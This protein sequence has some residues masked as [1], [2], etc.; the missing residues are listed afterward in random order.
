M[1]Y[2]SHLLIN[3]TGLCVQ[4]AHV[5]VTCTLSHSSLSFPSLFLS[6]FP[7]ALLSLAPFL[8]ISLPHTLPS[9]L[10]TSPSLSEPFQVSTNLH[11]RQ[12]ILFPPF[13][14]YVY[15]LSAS[16]HCCCCTHPLSGDINVRKAGITNA[17]PTV[18][19]AFEVIRAQDWLTDWLTD[20]SQCSSLVVVVGIL[21]KWTN[22]WT[23]LNESNRN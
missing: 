23:L 19:N 18:F 5:N 10:L 7:L 11:H 3:C 15:V 1:R 14:H 22:V 9:L 21:L 4:W 6:L 2:C 8:P 13:P 20:C 12:V 16:Y 17:A